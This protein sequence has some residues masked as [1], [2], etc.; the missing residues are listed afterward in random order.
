MKRL[1]GIL[2]LAFSPIAANA[3]IQVNSL[4]SCTGDLSI[5][6]LSDQPS[7]VGCT[8]SL[9]FSGASL[10]SNTPLEIWSANDLSFLNVLVLGPSLTFSAG[11]TILLDAQSQLIS[12]KIVLSANGLVLDGTIAQTVPEP[13]SSILAI[14]GLIGVAIAGRKKL[15]SV[16]KCGNA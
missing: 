13:A 15:H 9:S 4:V 3:N 8:G 12:P 14:I 5:S 10:T 2:L 16:K 1:F 11:G 6:A 7:V